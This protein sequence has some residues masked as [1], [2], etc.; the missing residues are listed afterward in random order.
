MNGG[1]PVRSGLRRP[2]LSAHRLPS[3]PP[4]TMN[5]LK[6]EREE[7]GMAGPI[8]GPPLTSIGEAS[9]ARD[10][11]Y[12]AAGPP[13]AATL[14]HHASLPHLATQ[15][16]YNVPLSAPASAYPHSG[17]SSGFGS[18]P[19][20]APAKGTAT[21]VSLEDLDT[22][23]VSLR[24]ALL[25]GRKHAAVESTKALGRKVEEMIEGRKGELETDEIAR[26]SRKVSS[27]P[28]AVLLLAP[29]RRSDVLSHCSVTCLRWR[30]TVGRPT[31]R[32]SSKAATACRDRQTCHAD[33]PTPFIILPSVHQRHLRSTT[34]SPLLSSQCSTSSR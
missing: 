9:F 7:L 34:A 31:R 24:D 19:P 25:E 17:S 32:P 6:R 23:Y 12:F 3:A 15:Q 18:G 4:Y 13:N 30:S 26:G 2:S 29:S 20:I 10:G 27:P 11:S 28:V 33:R 14:N 22:L 8:G 5:T 16:P 21:E 1:T